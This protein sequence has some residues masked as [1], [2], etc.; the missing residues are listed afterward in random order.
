M[1][2]A[3]FA[4]LAVFLSFLPL[5][6]KAQPVIWQQTTPATSFSLATRDSSGFLYF[7]TRTA[8]FMGRQLNVTKY[9]AAGVAQWTRQISSA[10]TLDI[11]FNIRDLALS[12]THL[13]VVFQERSSGGFGSLQSSRVMNF[14]KADGTTNIDLTSSAHEFEAVAGGTSYATVLRRNNTT[15][16]GEVMFI[17]QAGWSV[18][19]VANLGVVTRI[20]DIAMDA[21]DNAY[22]VTGD[23]GEAQLTKCSNAAGVVYQTV[24]TT[25]NYTNEVA[26]SIAIDPVANRAYLLGY[27][28]WH[29]SPF[30]YDAVLWVVDLSTGAQI[31][32]TGALA[33]TLDDE[34]GA[35]LVVPG[36]GVIVSG[37]TPSISTTSFRRY[38]TSGS[39]VW[40]RDVADSPGGYG[41]A[42]AYDAD[43]NVLGLTPTSGDTIRLSRIDVANGALLSTLTFPCG[44]GDVPLEIFTDAAGAAYVNYF[45]DVGSHLVRVQRADMSFSNNLITG[46]YPV[47]MQ[48]TGAAP[49]ASNELWTLS[50][51]NASVATVPASTTIT[52][53]NTSASATVT[54]FP[55]AANTNVSINARH[56][57]MI[58]QKTL[59]V[60]APQL[61]S[62]G[63][64][65]NSLIGGNNFSLTL[66]LTGQAPTGGRTITLSSSK[67]AVVALPATYTIPA[68]VAGVGISTATFA[69]NANQGVVLTATL[70]SVI[71][72]VFMAVNAPSLTNLVVS[73]AT[74]QGGTNSSLTLT[75]NGIAPTGGFAITLISGA[76]GIVLLPGTA[77]VAAGL[78]TRSLNFATTAVTSTVNVTLFATRAGIYRTATLTVTP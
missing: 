40:Q 41:R 62:I 32:I 26:S 5:T 66:T 15:N 77:S 51:S 14:S 3:L 60:L 43:G 67:P 18:S 53:G 24:Y 56:G 72:T 11:Q 61:A 74:V 2:R 58:L 44:T 8:T 39:Y 21:S 37:R 19:S 28:K 48:I 16:V 71:R 69:V 68:G 75:I 65:P 7:V 12:S 35:L 70:G 4:L 22:A 54:T 78:T 17:Q 55:V 64:S 42:Q 27:G 46:G 76:P 73:P 38:S 30:D 29:V 50:T 6:S 63:A 57:G 33:S 13:Y 47:T 52:A 20:E 25:S 59:T 23:G 31:N 36:N 34:D 10:G 1:N 45:D 49:A 9:N